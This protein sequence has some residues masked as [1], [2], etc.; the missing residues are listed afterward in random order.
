MQGGAF[1]CDFADDDE[2]GR[3]HFVA[4]AAGDVLQISANDFLRGS[5]AAADDG[6]RRLRGFSAEDEVVRNGGKRGAGHVKD[7]SGLL[8]VGE[9]PPSVGVHHILAAGGF[10]SHGAGDAPAGQR[11]SG[12]GRA[13]VCGGD[14][15]DDLKRN[16]FA[17]QR[18]GFFAAASEDEGVA[19][20][21][22]GDEFA[23]AGALD[24]GGGYLHL[25]LHFARAGFADKNLFGVA[26]REVQNAARNQSVVEDD[27]GL[28]QKAQRFKGHQFG[29]AGS[30]AD[31]KHFADG[32]FS[33]A[34]GARVVGELL[35]R[36]LKQ[37]VG[38]VVVAVQHCGGGGAFIQDEFPE[39]AADFFGE[40]LLDLFALILAELGELSEL[41][42][43]FGFEFVS[44][45]SGEDG[46][47]PAGGDGDADGVPVGECGKDEVAEFGLVDDI[48][49]DAGGLGVLADAL[50]EFGDSGGG[51]GDAALEEVGFAV[52]PVSDFP[53]G[54]LGELFQFG[55]HARRDNPRN[56]MGADEELGLA[57]GDGAPAHNQ[58]AGAP[59]VEKEWE[60]PHDN[61]GL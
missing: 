53:A 25:G 50:V 26:S 35:Q 27:I 21:Q 37:V 47:R 3:K 32:A 58:R 54:L 30:G 6:G 5:G 51:D 20:F 52:G 14:S 48:E 9:P 17:R 56:G 60:I 43:E 4:R 11:D 22:P 41:G 10:D 40:M 12:E 13:S 19:A 45:D 33:R 24:Q 18:L 29:I 44:Q 57:R 42:W 61:G 34:V 15:G 38:A 55:R 8:V 36:F 46:R 49:R 1:P 2:G 23:V 7:Q 16:S 28:L 39:A 59:Q 31:E